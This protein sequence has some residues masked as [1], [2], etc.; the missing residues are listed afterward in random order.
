MTETINLPFEVSAR[1]AR[2]I[3]RENIASPKGAII[4]LVKNA[5]D[6]D[7]E[8]CIVYFDIKIP[9]KKRQFTITEYESL[10]ALGIEN[11]TFVEACDYDPKNQ[12]YTI[13]PN[14]TDAVRSR[15]TKEISKY[16]SIFIIDSGEGMN[17]DIIRNHWMNIGTDNKLIDQFSKN[18]RIKSGAKG[19]GRFALDKLGRICEMTTVFNPKVHKNDTDIH[20][21]KT[22]FSGYKWRV[23]WDD[24]EG[25]GKKINQ[26]TAELT[27]IATDS[28]RQEVMSV[29]PE[30]VLKQFDA[31]NHFESGTILKISQLREDWVDENI[32][33]VYSDLE[34]L[35]PPRESSEF[36]LF[37]FYSQKENK[38][39]KVESSICDD[40]DYRLV[41]KADKT[42]R[43]QIRLYRREFDVELIPPVFFEKQKGKG[44]PFKKEE[45]TNGYIEKMMD[46]K[47]LLPGFRERSEED[48]LSLIG[49]FEFTFYYL[50]R[51]FNQR[52]A[53][54]F[55]YKN[56]QPNLRK[57]WLNKFGGIKLY[58]DNFRVRPYG[59]SKNSAFDWLNLG[60]RKAASPSGVAKG[61]AGYRVE[62]ENIA[63]SVKISRLGNELFQDKSSREG[64]QENMSF[65]YL[66]IY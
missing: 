60:N 18:G 15:F 47:Q 34:V 11:E 19:I 10:L 63:G 39:G 35:A 36:G 9:S 8:I 5:Y 54:R 7:S 33:E 48:S 17:Q 57:Q 53:K 16:N 31:T 29:L 26:V 45:F 52:D 32:D 59:E 44:S 24:F 2:L 12:Y 6:A 41:A 23:N 56:F 21:N 55:F 50:K 30:F 27:G 43:V 61:D 40:Y 22:N 20:G 46:F 64:L 38:Y 49:E 1:T 65:K 51:T 62:P 25:D 42:Q 14:L 3:G 58:R 13:K 37:F 28:I 4:E 66:K